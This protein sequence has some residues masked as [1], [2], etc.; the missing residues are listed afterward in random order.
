MLK[1]FDHTQFLFLLFGKNNCIFH[2][3]GLKIT[4]EV[5]NQIVNF[6]DVT[7]NLQEGKYS[8]NIIPNNEP[9]YIDSWSNHPPSIIKHIPKSINKRISSLPSSQSSSSQQ[10]PC[11]KTHSTAASIMSNSSTQQ[12]IP[13]TPQNQTERT[14]RERLYG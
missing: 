1:F 9:L 5:N 13:V 3:F 4:A 14:G 6:L 8:A 10:H 12:T 11:M 2:Q 7:F